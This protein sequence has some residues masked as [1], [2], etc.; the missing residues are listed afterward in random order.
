MAYN[1]R[2]MGEEEPIQLFS[3]R[4]EVLKVRIIQRGKGSSKEVAKDRKEILRGRKSKEE[5]RGKTDK[6]RKK[7]EKGKIA[8]R[9]DSEDWVKVGGRRS[10]DRRIVG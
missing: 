6:S 5:G 1:C 4:F 3:I 2:N 8:K 9:N 10:S 7:G